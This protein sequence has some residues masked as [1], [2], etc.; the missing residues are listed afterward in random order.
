L[1]KTGLAFYPIHLPEGM[2]F[3]L[4]VCMNNV[5]I[6]IDFHGKHISGVADPIKSVKDESVPTTHSIYLEGKFI[7]TLKCENKG[8]VM[9]RPA[10]LDLVETLG[11]YLHA[12][13]E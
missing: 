1:G 11:E 9:D 10:D 6:H 5:P 3:G 12:W 7:G 13:Y 8:W 2:P 4:P